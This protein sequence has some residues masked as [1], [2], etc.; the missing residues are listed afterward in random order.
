M[1][2]TSI[3][4][5]KSLRGL[6]ADRFPVPS[7]PKSAIL[8]PPMTKKYSLVGTAL[9]YIIRF[10]IKE[11]FPEAVTERWVAESAVDRIKLASGEYVEVDGI[12]RPWDRS[13]EPK[14]QYPASSSVAYAKEHSKTL[15]DAA[16]SY[17]HE[18]G[19]AKNLY[20]GFVRT[21]V[22]TRP[23]LE[24]SLILATLDLVIRTG[25]PYPMP[26]VTTNDLDDMESLY[27]TMKD[28]GLLC[29]K[30]RAFLNPTFGPGSAL[31]GGADADLIIDDTLIDIKTTKSDSFTQDMYNQLLG[32]YALSTLGDGFGGITR[33]GI[34][35]SRYGTL[36]A[37]PVPGMDDVEAIIGWFE[38]YGE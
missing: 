36:H 16:S 28:S 19:K 15:A 6:F 31:V 37:V 12:V 1:S 8:V 24:S 38:E 26:A 27:G 32:Y 34:Y 35:F 21:G 4:K 14:E 30:E 33:M 11:S 22:M 20:E 9:D 18:L 13:M 23:L 17:G 2:L 25:R 7:M 29:P 10:H 3:L 5:D